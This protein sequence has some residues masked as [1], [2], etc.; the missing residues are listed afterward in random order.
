MA[1]PFDA[2]L[3]ALGSNHSK[4]LGACR[5]PCSRICAVVVQRGMFSRSTTPCFDWSAGT[6]RATGLRLVAANAAVLLPQPNSPGTSRLVYPT[7]VPNRAA[8]PPWAGCLGL[9]FSLAVKRTAERNVDTLWRIRR[10][11]ET[12]QRPVRLIPVAGQVRPRLSSNP[13][14]CA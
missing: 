6:C 4:M 13:F 2:Q 12:L 5:R 8:A 7:N 11:A 9:R 14:H 3:S 10:S 1:R